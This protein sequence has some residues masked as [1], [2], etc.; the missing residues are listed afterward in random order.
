MKFKEVEF[1]YYG[2][3]ISKNAF[4]ELIE[5]FLPNSSIERPAYPSQGQAPIDYYFSDKK[6]SRFMRWRQGQDNNSGDLWELTSKIKTNSHDNNIREEINI[7]LV[8]KDMSFDKA[9]A[10]SLMHGLEHDFS[11]RKDVQVYWLDRVVFSRYTT[12]D[13]EGAMLDTFIEIEANEE[14]PWTDEKAAFDEIVYWESK[15]SPLGVKPEDRI[16]KSLFELYSTK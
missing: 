12:F 8:S 11:I 13:I 9:S 6:T 1:K 5:G 7:P 2:L 4:C 16:T 15:L 3:R 10:F 14:F